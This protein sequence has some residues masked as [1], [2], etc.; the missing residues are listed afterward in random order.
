MNDKLLKKKNPKARQVVL[1]HSKKV[2]S[3]RSLRDRALLMYVAL[4]SPD[5]GL[6]E[7][8]L[9]LSEKELG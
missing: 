5:S 1:G 2:K 9:V 8:H 4:I 3:A 7:P 6:L